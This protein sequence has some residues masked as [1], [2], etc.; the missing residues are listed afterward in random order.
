MNGPEY[1]LANPY[2]WYAH[3]RERDPVQRGDAPSPLFPEQWLLFR[4]E[5]VAAALR[6]PRLGR[7]WHAV[8]DPARVKRP[9][10][11]ERLRALVALVDSWMLF[12]DPPRHGE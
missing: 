9:E 7:D 2:P 4:H 6:D 10:L 12:V 8:I 3:Q 1:S 11:P 5:D